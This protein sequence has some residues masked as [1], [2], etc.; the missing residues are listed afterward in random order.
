MLSKK[1]RL[2][3]AQFDRA[4]SVGK[5]VH[6]SSLQV[7][8]APSDSFHGSVVVGKK[9]FKKAVDRNKLRRVLYAQLYRFSKAHDVPYTYIVITKPPITKIQK[10]VFI[11]E[12]HTALEKASKMLS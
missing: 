7:I 12:L 10:S 8:V 3:R 5:R 4:F 11:E 9:V 2:P 1:E 6:A